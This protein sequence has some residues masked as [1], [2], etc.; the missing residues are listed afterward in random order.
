MA[1]SQVIRGFDIYT[2]PSIDNITMYNWYNLF[3]VPD[4]SW[5]LSQN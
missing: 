5:I 2:I 4:E 1:F 3:A